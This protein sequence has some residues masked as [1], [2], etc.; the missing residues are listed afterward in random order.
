MMHMIGGTY[1]A[2]HVQRSH[3]WRKWGCGTEQI[4][5]H[6]S[7]DLDNMPTAD[8]DALKTGGLRA[9]LNIHLN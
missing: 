9:L 3:N 5:W 7:M 6:F 4:E 1:S 2:S 8:G